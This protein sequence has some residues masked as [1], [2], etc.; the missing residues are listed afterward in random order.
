MYDESIFDRRRHISRHNMTNRRRG[1]QKLFRAGGRLA[2]L[3]EDDQ[4]S[5]HSS[6][7]H[8]IASSLPSNLT[9]RLSWRSSPQKFS[10]SD[11]SKFQL[12]S[13]LSITLFIHYCTVLV[14]RT[15][16]RIW[17]ETKQQPGTAGTGNMLGC[18]LVSFHFLWA[19]LSTSTVH[20]H[21]R[22]LR[23]TMIHEMFCRPAAAREGIFRSHDSWLLTPYID[24][25]KGSQSQE[26]SSSSSPVDSSIW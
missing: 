3:R 2:H 6:Q 14:L 15:A 25:E 5:L 7:H 10:F 21:F 26:S 13:L 22:Y 20:S 23:F 1:V 24:F 4:H 9:R 17:K 18:C 11:R 12:F 19:I 8:S 16:H